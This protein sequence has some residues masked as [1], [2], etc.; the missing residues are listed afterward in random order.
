M[1]IHKYMLV[2]VGKK[3]HTKNWP[4][5]VNLNRQN[6][7]L[8]LPSGLLALYWWTLSVEYYRFVIVWPDEHGTD[9]MAVDSMDE[10]RRER[11][12]G[13]EEL[14]SKYRIRPGCGK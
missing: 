14:V 11:R 2:G 3:G 5:A 13:G 7:L 8:E 12:Q 10:D 6:A 9:P 4:H 1:T